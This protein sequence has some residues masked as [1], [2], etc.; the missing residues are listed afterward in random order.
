MTLFITISLFLARE[1][2]VYQSVACHLLL[3]VMLKIVKIR[4]FKPGNSAAWWQLELIL[5][6]YHHNLSLEAH[7]AF[8]SESVDGGFVYAIGVPR[9]YK[10]LFEKAH[11][12]GILC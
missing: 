9:L 1:I 6:F 10:D 5:T 11:R 4:C 8:Q 2:T 7:L 3:M 12:A